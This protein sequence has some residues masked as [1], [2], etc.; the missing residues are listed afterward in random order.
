MDIFR[1]KVRIFET[2]GTNRGGYFDVT[3]LGAGVATELTPTFYFLQAHASV[4]YTLPGSYTN[5]PC[6]YS[7]VDI[8]A[9][10]SSAWFNTS[11]YIFT[12]LKSGYW[13][14]LASYDV[15]RGSSTEAGLLLQKMQQW[16]L[17]L[18]LLER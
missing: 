5:D 9:N 10:V 14:I 18:V 6:R 3:K 17:Q 13:Q 1:D 7:I 2:G 12:P 11:T 16:F 8:S 4:T 15:F